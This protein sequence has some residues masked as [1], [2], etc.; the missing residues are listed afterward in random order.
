MMPILT[1][2]QVAERLGITP[3]A[4]RALAVRHAVGTCLTPR[5]RVY[6]EA[7]VARLAVRVGMRGKPM[8]RT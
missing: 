5:L 6:S 4:V 3:R 8:P 2:Q 7:D 1:T